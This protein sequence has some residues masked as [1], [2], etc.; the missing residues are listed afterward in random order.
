MSSGTPKSDITMDHSSLYVKKTFHGK[1]VNWSYTPHSIEQIDSPRVT[2]VL[3]RAL[4]KKAM[5][6]TDEARDNSHH[7]TNHTTC[8]TTPD[9][10]AS[11][12]TA[13]S[14]T[15]TSITRLTDAFPTD[16]P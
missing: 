6:T 5:L 11:S 13:T 7:S 3:L 14:S 4:L 9:P 1:V 12:P 8:I 2:I 15:P 10:A 16:S